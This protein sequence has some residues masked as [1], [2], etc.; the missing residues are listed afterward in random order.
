MKSYGFFALVLIAF[1]AFAG[2]FGPWT[3]PVN[4]GPAVNSGYQDSAPGLS[5]N[6]LS[7]YFQ[8]Q[9]PGLGGFDIYVSQRASE[10]DPWGPPVMLGPEINSTWSDVAPN[11]SRDGHYLFFCSNRR[12]GNLNDFDLYVAYREF[13]HDD[14]SWQPA[15]PIT[16]LNTDQMDA[17]PSYFENEGG[18]PQLY[19]AHGPTQGSQHI[20]MSEMQEDGTW[21]TPHPV[22]EL[23]SP[24]NEARPAIRWD[25]L[26]IVFNSTRGGNQDLYVSRRNSVSDPWSA[27]EPITAVNTQYG[28]TQAALSADGTALYFG[29]DRPGSMLGDL[30]VSTRTKRGN[31]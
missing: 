20:W 2:D 24:I 15:T 4:L 25:G 17:G 31:H 7:L 16:E 21:G 19:F 27:P 10:N 13:T 22:T 8:S 23:N 14:F 1:S 9:R 30:W 3:T 18:R 29:S 11:L 5:K 12:T 6:G 28:E 26:E